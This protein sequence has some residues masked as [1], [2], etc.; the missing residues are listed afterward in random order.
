M[1]G[2]GQHHCQARQDRGGALF[3]LR[4]DSATTTAATSTPPSPGSPVH[5]TTRRLSGQPTQLEATC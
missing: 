4:E 1:K 3:H 2:G 5:E